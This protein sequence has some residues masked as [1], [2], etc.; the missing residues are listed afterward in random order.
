MSV[1]IGEIARIAAPEHI[2]QRLDGLCSRL[3]GESINLIGLLFGA[4]IVGKRDGR[5]AGGLVLDAGILSQIG[6]TEKSQ[7]QAVCLEE[8]DA[9]LAGGRC[10]PA[11]GFVEGTRLWNIR[12][13]ERDEGQSRLHQAASSTT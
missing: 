2:L 13:A 12:D 10:L 9:G 11:P 5:K 6:A 1:R 7:R 3:H 4:G 8:S